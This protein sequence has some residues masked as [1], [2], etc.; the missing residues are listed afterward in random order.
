MLFR[1]ADFGREI[2]ASVTD[3]ELIKQLSDMRSLVFPTVPDAMNYLSSIGYKFQQNYVTYDKEGKPDAT[4]MVFEKRMPRR[5]PDGKPR[6]EGVRAVEGEITK[7][8]PA[9]APV[10]QPKTPTKEN[11]KK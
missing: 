3:K 7:E 11:K 5:M 8:G 6:P 4:H 2:L 9:L 1:S 10:P